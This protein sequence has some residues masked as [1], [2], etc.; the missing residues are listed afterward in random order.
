[1]ARRAGHRQL[2]P[3]PGAWRLDWSLADRRGPFPWPEVRTE[4]YG[5]LASFLASLNELSLDEVFCIER[6]NCKSAIHPLDF[7]DLSD[8]AKGRWEQLTTEKSLDEDP[9]GTLDIVTMTYCLEQFD[10]RRVTVAFDG[11][12]RIV[13]PLWWDPKHRVSG[14]DGT[15][16]AHQECHSSNCHHLPGR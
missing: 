16:R 9:Y 15:T 5:D 1:M 10:S 2:S 14:T 11:V 8:L 3:D 4:L 12:P 13:Y 6:A 7:K